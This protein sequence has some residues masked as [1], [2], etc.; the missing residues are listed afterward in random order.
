METRMPP[1]YM[2]ADQRFASRRPDVL[3]YASEPLAKP[4][5][6]AGPIGVELYVSTT[7]AD[8]DWIIKV[9]DVYPNDHSD[10]DP[11][12]R[13]IKM[14]GYQ[15][16][17]RGEVM[18]GRF[19]NSLEKPEP[20]DAGKPSL[21]RFNLPDVCHTFRPGHKIMVHVHSTWFPLVERNPQKYVDIAH[22][23]PD[24][25]QKATQRVYRSSGRASR[26]ILPVRTDASPDRKDGKAP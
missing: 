16:L 12:P 25:F 26:L 15:Q 17:V 22:A 5:T 19:R 11:N 4:M 23:K 6:L 7:G 24:D 8:A 1:E 3:V 2:C 18:R 9:I 20:M 13:A 21:I 10:P 14:G